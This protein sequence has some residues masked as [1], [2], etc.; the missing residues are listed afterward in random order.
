MKRSDI[1]NSPIW[2]SYIPYNT[3]T[4]RYWYFYPYTVVIF[5]LKNREKN[6]GIFADFRKAFFGIK[7]RE[8][9]IGIF[10]HIRWLFLA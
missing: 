6:M 1:S 7:N 9:N 8:K 2:L 10:T 3:A 5:D 4:Y